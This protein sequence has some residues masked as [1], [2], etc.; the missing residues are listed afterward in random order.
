MIFLGELDGKDD[1]IKAYC[2]AN[3]IER[4]V[5]LTPPQFR[6][7]HALAATE[8]VEWA[9]IIRYEFFYRLLREID[10]ETLVVVNE[11]LQTQNRYDLTYN[12]IRHYLQKTKHQIVFQYA[13]LIDSKEDFM[14]LFDFDTQSRW[15]RLGL[16]D[17]PLDESD[18]RMSRRSFKFNSIPVSVDDATKRSYSA[19][20]R[21]L[22]DG[23]GLRDPH[24]IPRN[25]YLFGSKI[26]A[27]FAAANGY[28]GRNFI[29]RSKPRMLPHFY[30]WKKTPEKAKDF[31]IFEFPHRF[32]DFLHFAFASRQRAF[33]VL[34]AELPV[35]FWYFQ[36]YSD[37]SKRIDDLYSDLS[38]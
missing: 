29:G 10:D 19:K 35:E 1:I 7:A 32:L 16:R 2:E 25:L 12:C 24:T 11:C 22:F 13:P 38:K 5:I 8:T 31:M 36:R 18:I 27:A 17:A 21:A 3:H 26:K 37:W 9:D 33:D 4:V 23:L 30:T 34:T 6:F 14:I 20:K 15:K 28:S